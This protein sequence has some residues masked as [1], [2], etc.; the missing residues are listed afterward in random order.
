MPLFL[1]EKQTRPYLKEQKVEIYASNFP[2]EETVNE[3]KDLR[4]KAGTYQ[5]MSWRKFLTSNNLFTINYKF[6]QL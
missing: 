6:N 2:N 4:I 5:F 3:T 1:K